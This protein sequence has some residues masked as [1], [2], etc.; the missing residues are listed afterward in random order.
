[1]ADES[2]RRRRRARRA[3]A[4][5]VT[6]GPAPA[7]PAA[8]SPAAPS[9]AVP[10]SEGDEAPQHEERDTERGLRG[11]IGGG[12]SQVR[13]PAALRARDAT[14]PSAA[15]VAAAEAGLMIVRRGWT[16]P[17]SPR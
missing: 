11:L 16:P 5:D 13:V 14:R 17:A 1:M 7:S 4:A 6:A 15:H 8:P 2:P 9:A 3:G 10:D 12:S